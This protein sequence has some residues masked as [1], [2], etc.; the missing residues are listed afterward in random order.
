MMS[1]HAGTVRTLIFE[2]V[3]IL[4]N[5]RISGR[6]RRYSDEYLISGIR[7]KHFRELVGRAEHSDILDADAELGWIIIQTAHC[8]V[9]TPRPVDLAQD[10]P[11]T[12][13]C[14]ATTSALP[15][16]AH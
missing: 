2:R 14:S 9:R 16:L 3:Q 5:R 13:F 10:R 12:L 6:R 11:C 4:T 1:F 7:G 15:A 8:N